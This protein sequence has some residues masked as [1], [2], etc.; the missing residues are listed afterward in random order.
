MPKST[1][2][3]LFVLG[4]LLWSLLEYL[5]HR[6]LFH[7]KPP[8]NS[9]YL[10][11]LHFILHGQHHKVSGVGFL[12]GSCVANYLTT[13]NCQSFRGPC[14]AREEVRACAAA[15]RKGWALV[16]TWCGQRGVCVCMPKLPT[17][18]TLGH[19]SC[20][21]FNRNPQSS[22]L[23]HSFNK[24]S[25][26]ARSMPGTVLDT[27]DQKSPRSLPLWSCRLKVVLQFF[28]LSEQQTEAWGS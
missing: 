11:T 4:M 20:A 1:F 21:A 15:Q 10:I 19:F 12:P 3:G 25:L 5:L 24:C 26:S 22:L 7:M 23:I 14:W 16:W 18:G 13:A 2:P 9:Y 6:F 17:P 27:V 28:P 8:G